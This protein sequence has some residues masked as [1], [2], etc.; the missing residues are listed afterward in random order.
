MTAIQYKPV[1][2]SSNNN[3][4]VDKVT[5]IVNTVHVEVADTIRPTQTC[6]CAS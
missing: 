3:Y 6:F 1:F 2:E 4:G 5:E